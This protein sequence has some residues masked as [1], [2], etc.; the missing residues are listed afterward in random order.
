MHE[1]IW[2]LK[3][4]SVRAMAKLLFLNSNE[5]LSIPLHTHYE[6]LP[7]VGRDIDDELRGGW[8]DDLVDNDLPEVFHDWLSTGYVMEEHPDWT[9]PQLM[10]AY[11][12]Y[13]VHDA[14]R[15]LKEIAP[16]DEKWNDY[17]WRRDETIEHCAANVIAALECVHYGRLLLGLKLVPDPRSTG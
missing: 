9:P 13:L 10:A 2:E 5:N 14:A 17:G 3:F 15:I 6:A 4:S 16:E 8:D 12:F 11:A 7:V 1:V